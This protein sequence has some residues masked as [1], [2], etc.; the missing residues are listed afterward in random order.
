MLY[1]TAFCMAKKSNKFCSFSFHSIQ[2]FHN[3]EVLMLPENICKEHCHQYILSTNSRNVT[4]H[5]FTNLIS[6]P[7]HLVSLYDMFERFPSNLDWKYS[8]LMKP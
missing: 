5:S 1:F 8:I 4:R 7:S 6:P 2:I 3:N